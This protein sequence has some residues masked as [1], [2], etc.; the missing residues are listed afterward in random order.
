MSSYVHQPSDGRIGTCLGDDRSAL[1]V[2]HEDARATL[3]KSENALSSGNIIF[4]GRFWFLHD[5]DVVTVLH[6]NVV[7]TFPTRAV[8]PSSVNQN[9]IPNSL[10]FVGCRHRLTCQKQ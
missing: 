8:C 9:N 1:T 7:N 6:Q 3:L 10:R 2:S 4:K 5:A